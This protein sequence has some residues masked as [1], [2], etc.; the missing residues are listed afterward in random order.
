[1]VLFKK[2][3]TTLAAPIF[4]LALSTSIS[5]ADSDNRSE[6][7]I[8]KLVTGFYRSYLNNAENW[9]KSKSRTEIEAEKKRI[10]RTSLSPGFNRKFHELVIGMDMDPVL[11]AQ[12]WGEDFKDEINVSEIVS[13]DSTHAQAKVTLGKL[14]QGLKSPGPSQLKVSLV[15]IK[16]KW[17][18]DSVGR[19]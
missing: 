11:L 16:G 9:V 5:F 7:D 2:T 3:L 4:Y 17:T 6:R 13:K 14:S 18:I 1:M 10:L 15:K 19:P 12:E 8:V